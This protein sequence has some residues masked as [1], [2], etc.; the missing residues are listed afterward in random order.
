[1]ALGMSDNDLRRCV[2]QG[3]LDRLSPGQYAIQAGGTGAE[4]LRASVV[5][6][7]NR[8]EAV[9]RPH[10]ESV[11]ALRSSAIA[12]DLPVAAVPARPEIIRPPV[13]S[14]LIGTRTIRTALRDSDV[15]NGK[16]FRATSLARTAVDLALD[17]PTPEALITVDAALRRGVGSSELKA[18]LRDRGPIRGRRRAGRT[19]DW[20]D[21][22]AETPLE[23]W[24]R[25]V[26]MQLG[27][28]RP[29]CNVVVGD[30]DQSFRVDT[31]WDEFGVVG[32]A[33]GRIK[34]QGQLVTGRTLWKEKLRQ[35]WL[36]NE[37]GFKVVRWT[38]Q[39]LRFSAQSVVDR[40]RRAAG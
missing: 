19:L 15:T 12:W 29:R 37:A 38:Y 26:L 20:A 1:M 32:E 2:R 40:W 4:T 35:E 6:H 14:R 28:P 16:R 11:A 30:H 25:G 8:V 13:S 5:S 31:L 7:L 22:G 33:D 21:A 3:L 10:A 17:L 39:E 9:L 27:I 18:L 36:E 23:S 34:Y 24:S